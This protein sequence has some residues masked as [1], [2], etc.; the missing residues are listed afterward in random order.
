MAPFGS[1]CEFASFADC[2]A[3]N[4]DK[5]D[6]SAYCAALKDATEEYCKQ[7]SLI[8]SLAYPAPLSKQQLTAI[9]EMVYDAFS[10]GPRYTDLLADELFGQ[11]TSDF[12]AAIL[13][14]A[15]VAGYDL[16]GSLKVTDPMVLGDLR[17]RAQFA[18]SSISDT[19]NAEMRRQIAR[20]AEEVPTANRATYLK[21]LADWD[22]ARWQKHLPSISVTELGTAR[23]YAQVDFIYRNQ[24]TGRA[25]VDPQSAIC[26]NC[27]DLVLEGW[28]SL[29]EG[30][31]WSVPLHVNCVISGTPVV[32]LGAVLAASRMAYAGPV[33]KLLTESGAELVLTPNHPVL[34][35]RGW[36]PAKSV[37]QGD[38]VFRSLREHADAGGMETDN[39]PALIDEIFRALSQLR[40]PR[41]VIASAADFH[42]DGGFAEGEIEVVAGDGQLPRVGG[43]QCI[44]QGGESVLQLAGADQPC[45]AGPGAG[46]EGGQLISRAPSARPSAL[47]NGG[48]SRD[49]T[50]TQDVA[51][52]TGADTVAASDLAHGLA[53]EVI[54]DHV[55]IAETLPQHHVAHVYDL[56]TVSGAYLAGG[57]IVHNCVH[58][59]EVEYD[60]AGRPESPWLGGD[61]EEAA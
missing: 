53:G 9:Q 46:Q 13:Q 29:E 4:Q 40:M 30:Y 1:S 23:N 45:L 38:T 11:A 32:P 56:Q 31:T 51:D 18:A 12:G 22:A 57:I 55:V 59:L 58:S 2:V 3:A 50:S 10:V 33:R 41:K 5:D 36:L 7:K 37:R 61:L 27:E 6:P 20:I 17:D 24:L 14:E 34:T 52:A 44:E 35:G 54:L 42:G 60:E 25:R 48:A 16:A 47:A 19:Y 39:G 43:S 15:R 21:R 49:S 26:P 8:L 28:V